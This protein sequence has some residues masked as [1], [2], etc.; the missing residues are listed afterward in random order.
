MLNLYIFFY[1]LYIFVFSIAL[2]LK[3]LCGLYRF[4]S[5]VNS[6]RVVIEQAFG[7]LKNRWRILKGFNMSVDKAALVTLACCVLHNY[8][9][10]HRQRVPIPA[11]VILQRDPYVGFHVGRMQLP[12]EG[13]AA[14]LAREAMRDICLHHGWNVIHDEFLRFRV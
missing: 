6:G 14:K 1:F 5:S 2:L 3:L 8:C 7:A 9:E 10:I 13:L 4:D 11:Y 12:R